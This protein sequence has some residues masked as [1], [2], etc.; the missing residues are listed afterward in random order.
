MLHL[1]SLRCLTQLAEVYISLLSYDH[2]QSLTPT[3]VQ[4]IKSFVF[5]E[6]GN[7]QSPNEAFQIKLIGFVLH[8]QPHKTNQPVF[9]P[10]LAHF[11]CKFSL[12]VY[13]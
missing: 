5:I 9:Q 8:V 11:T 6:N 1:E 7:N 13:Q 12:S 3:E 2:W 4:I 10:M